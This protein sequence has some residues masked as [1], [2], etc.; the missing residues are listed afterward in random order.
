MS[1]EDNKALARRYW[2]EGWSTGNVAIVDELFAPDNSFHPPHRT[3]ALR[4]TE[5]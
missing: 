3:T 5:T 1:A 4:G 2:D